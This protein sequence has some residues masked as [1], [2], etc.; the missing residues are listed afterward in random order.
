M[1]LVH[2]A[3]H[4]GKDPEVRYTSNGQKVTSFSMAV[5][6]RKGGEETT[7]WARVTIWGD[8]FDKMVSFMKKGSGVI[9]SGRL[10]PSI[11]TDKEGRAQLSLDVT[12][13]MM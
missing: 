9:V 12:A 7:V 10:N 13:E 8:K 6:Q 4:L 11:Y 1:F 3:G 5:N 2:I